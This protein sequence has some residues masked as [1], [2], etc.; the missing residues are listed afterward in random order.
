MKLL[1]FQTI[2]YLNSC[3]ITKGP[4]TKSLG[5]PQGKSSGR[6]TLWKILQH[7]NSLVRS[8]CFGGDFLPSFPSKSFT[9]LACAETDRPNTKQTFARFG[10][11]K[12]SILILPVH[13]RS[14]HI[15]FG[16]VS[17]EQDC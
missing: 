2:K 15:K 5:T 17:F 7:M 9:P 11:R 3:K 10:K 12:S 16:C 4:Q 8:F 1:I 14:F 13:E 6:R